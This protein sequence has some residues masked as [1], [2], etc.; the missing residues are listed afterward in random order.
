[1]QQ[2]LPFGGANYQFSWDGS[3]ATTDAPRTVFSP[4]LGSH[5]N[6]SYTQ[7]LLRNFKIDA[8]RQQLYQSRNLQ[9]MADIQ[10][11]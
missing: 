4:Q 7:P 11:R 1:M 9:Q 5:L 3:R 2:Q 8:F 10:L 6:A